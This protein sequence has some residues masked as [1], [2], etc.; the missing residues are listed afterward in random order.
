MASCWP[1]VEGAGGTS[2]LDASRNSA[3]AVKPRLRRR[4]VQHDNG[5]QSLVRFVAVHMPPCSL[6]RPA[7]RAAEC[8]AL[9]R[10]GLTVVHGSRRFHSGTARCIA[11]LRRCIARAG[12]GARAGSGTVPALSFGGPFPEQN[13]FRATLAPRP[14]RR[15][16]RGAPT[17]G[18]CDCVWSMRPAFECRDTIMPSYYTTN[19]RP[20]SR[21]ESPS[22]GQVDPRCGRTDRGCRGFS[23]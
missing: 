14:R 20:A 11:G 8:P 23:S 21:R 18:S 19:G 6:A 2:P 1:T 17:P 22:R 10:P 3:Q 9:R 12:A 7:A 4:L 13:G 15:R 16:R 5:R